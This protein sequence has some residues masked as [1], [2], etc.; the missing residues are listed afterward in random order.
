MK[1]LEIRDLTIHYYTL[2]GIVHAVEGVNLSV[3][4]GERVAIVGESGSGKTTLGL[5]ITGLLPAPG[6][7]AKGNIVFKGIDLARLSSEEWRKIRGKEISI[8]FQDP[9][10]ALNPVM[11]IGDQVAEILIA[12]GYSK[13]EAREKTIELLKAVGIPDPHAR[14][15][16]YPHQLSGGMKQR[17]V[18]A[19][20]VALKPSLI[21]ADEPTSALDVTI[22]SLILEMMRDLSI[23]SGS[24]LI[25]IT[26]DLGVAAEVADKIAVMYAG[27]LVEYG[28]TREV[29]GNPLHPYTLRLLESVP[30]IHKSEGELKAIPGSVPN[31]LNPPKGCRFHP[32]C[33]RVMSICKTAEPPMVEVNGRRVAC[34]LYS[35]R[36]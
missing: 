34:H 15:D 9:S 3:E 22:Q 11:K 13:K 14:Y 29:I 36:R 23:K 4:Q 16:S 25:L 20:S 18:I 31:L 1:V 10:S 35:S 32:R 12:H 24:S 30:F 17:V 27:R 28:S 19:I 33:H 8:I 7:I 2:R 5:A 26:H 21:I 6:R